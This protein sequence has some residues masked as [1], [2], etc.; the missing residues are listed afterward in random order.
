[1]KLF[2]LFM[3]ALIAIQLIACDGGGSD[4]PETQ[5]IPTNVISGEV[6]S[7]LDTNVEYNSLYGIGRTCPE[8]VMSDFYIETDNFL[9]FG[10]EGVTESTKQLVGSYAENALI[11][12]SESLGYSAEEVTSNRSFYPPSTYEDDIH[13]FWS[14]EDENN[15]GFTIFE[16]NEPFIQGFSNL[17]DSNKDI[18]MYQYWISLTP[19]EQIDA[20]S[21]IDTAFEFDRF[22]EK[23]SVCITRNSHAGVAYDDGF[24]VLD[25]HVAIGTT[26]QGI[27]QYQH[28]INHEFTHL[29]MGLITR[30]EDIRYAYWFDEGL[31]EYISGH[32]PA[33]NAKSLGVNVVRDRIGPTVTHL[34]Q[35]PT[36]HFAVKYLAENYGNGKTT[37]GEFLMEIRNDDLRN[38]NVSY[39]EVMHPELQIRNVF[40]RSFERTFKEP[41]GATVTYQ[42]YIDIYESLL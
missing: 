11:T 33:N 42:D 25:P 38:G 19:Q 17:S 10:H 13:R 34:T 21:R 14:R 22:G 36:F 1:M 32:Q 20:V 37:I 40:L 27:S 31:A 2:K 24:E 12:V 28:L 15:P 39:S 7:S 23:M 6:K 35:Y 8:N 18:A 4:G 5:A 29:V 16:M 9:V 41:S 30:T 3:V 26:T